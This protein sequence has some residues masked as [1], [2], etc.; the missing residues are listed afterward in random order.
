VESFEPVAPSRPL[1]MPPPRSASP[2]LAA[3]SPHLD[4]TY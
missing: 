1:E 4:F 3:P 2:E